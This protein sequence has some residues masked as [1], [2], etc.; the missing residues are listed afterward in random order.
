MF[1]TW[2]CQVLDSGVMV[3][4]SEAALGWC[5]SLSH[6]TICVCPQGAGQPWA[7]LCP[8]G[9]QISKCSSLSWVI[10]GWCS[11]TQILV[12]CFPVQHDHELWINLSTQFCTGSVSFHVKTELFKYTWFHPGGLSGPICCTS[13]VSALDG[14]SGLQL[15]LKLC[16]MEGGGCQMNGN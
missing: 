4:C 2:A 14:T 13:F 5:E 7:V 11:V 16:Y 12:L 9:M 6:S 1:L 15:H 8:R 3:L 10:P